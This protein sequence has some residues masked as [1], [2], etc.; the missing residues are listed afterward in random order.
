[1]NGNKRFILILED[2]QVCRAPN[3]NQS[4]FVVKHFAVLTELFRPQPA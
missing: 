2:E 1:M 3:F 4:P